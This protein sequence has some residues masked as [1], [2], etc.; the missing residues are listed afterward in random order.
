[1]MSVERQVEDGF[2]GQVSH[3]A[4]ASLLWCSIGVSVATNRK[5]RFIGWRPMIRLYGKTM[6]LGYFS[7][8]VEAALAYDAVARKHHGDAAKL[9]FPNGPP[10][11]S[12]KK[13][14][15]G[16]ACGQALI[17]CD[18]ENRECVAG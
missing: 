18:K 1:M 13:R 17:S 3:V 8:E 14:K 10:S 7:D 15:A 12:D 11:S 4:R 16:E 6:A 5:G 9:N 2:Q